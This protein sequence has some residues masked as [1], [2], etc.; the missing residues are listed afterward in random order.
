M[1]ATVPNPQRAKIIR[2]DRPQE[3]TTRQKGQEGFLEEGT[4][5]ISGRRRVGAEKA[6]QAP[7]GQGWGISGKA[8][9]AGRG[10][11]P[12]RWEAQAKVRQQGLRC[13]INVLPKGRPGGSV[14]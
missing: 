2:E 11:G 4:V 3:R 12:D 7:G 5:H 14:R 1:E 13:Q 8:G 10:R 6:F 9:I